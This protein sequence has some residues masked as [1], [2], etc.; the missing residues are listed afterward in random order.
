MVSLLPMPPALP[1]CVGALLDAASAGMLLEENSGGVEPDCSGAALL[2][3][4]ISVL[5]LAA[6]LAA[7]SVVSLSFMLDDTLVIS[8][9]VS[10]V[11]PCVFVVALH[12]SVPSRNAVGSAAS[13]TVKNSF[14]CFIVVPLNPAFCIWTL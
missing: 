4:V 8:R 9:G 7:E 5:E 11:V 10:V 12:P 3:D 14:M 2:E 6:E 13:N 1:V